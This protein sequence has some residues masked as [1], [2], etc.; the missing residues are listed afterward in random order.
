MIMKKAIIVCGP[1]SAGNHLLESL[2]NGRDRVTVPGDEN[3]VHTMARLEDYLKRHQGSNIVIQRSLPCNREW[4]KFD[5][6][7]LGTFIEYGFDIKVIVVSR[8]W[9]AMMKSQFHKHTP[10]SEGEALNNIRLA[11]NL[12]FTELTAIKIPYV[13]VNY[14]ALVHQREETLKSLEMLFDMR[15]GCSGIVVKDGNRK[16][17]ES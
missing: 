6:Y 10:C 11:Y 12:L 9:R 2:L 7:L 4:W 1:E 8:E 14:E 13:I 3:E 15:F 5:S 16:W 17:Y